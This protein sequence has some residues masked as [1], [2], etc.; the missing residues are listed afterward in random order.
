MD[1]VFREGI[2]YIGLNNSIN[3]NNGSVKMFNL[4]T[5]IKIDGDSKIKNIIQVK[6]EANITKEKEVKTP[7]GISLEGAILTGRKLFL[8]GYLNCSIQYSNDIDNTHIQRYN[9]KIKFMESLNLPMEYTYK[10][11]VI[12][13]NPY[14]VDISIAKI[15]DFSAY[16]TAIIQINLEY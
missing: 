6:C 9:K 2:N 12:N 10:S 13:S 5:E 8:S 11:R 15:D 3:V 4:A 16:L 7:K 14:I 1:T